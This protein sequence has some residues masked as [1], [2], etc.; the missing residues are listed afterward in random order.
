MLPLRL[1][2]RIE[3]T[4]SSFA[5]VL[6]EAL[7]A[8]GVRFAFGVSGGAIAPLWDC[9]TRS[10]IRVIHCRHETGAVFAATEASLAEN[11]PTVVFVTAGPGLSNALTGIYS[12]RTEGA[13]VIVFSGA[14][15]PALRRRNAFQESNV[16]ALPLSGLY[17]DGEIV[18]YAATPE[19]TGEIQTAIRRLAVGITR[20]S[21]FTAQIALPAALQASPCSFAASTGPVQTALPAPSP[22]I[23]KR[24]I[25]R[26]ED[27]PFMTWIGHGARGAAPLV[28]ALAEKTGCPV[29]CS[30]RAKGIFPEQHPQFVGVSGFGGHDTVRQMMQKWAPRRALVLGTRL[31]EFTSG[32][33][34]DLVPPE[35]F[36]HVDGEPD[37][38]WKPRHHQLRGRRCGQ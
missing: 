18:H 22:Q 2:D 11:A 15:P 32:Y 3:P 20:A 29:L 17:A 38:C 23:I 25:E 36:I 7:Y 37:L 14:T 26:L 6:V 30:A 27:G 19:S 4:S 9:L 33:A 24:C 1:T 12:A 10:P 28:R 8:L 34:T 31:G 13:K 16:Q 21:G 35:G 5:E